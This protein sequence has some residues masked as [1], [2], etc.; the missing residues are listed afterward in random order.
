LREQFQAVRHY[1]Q[2]K[3]LPIAANDNETPRL[4][5][6]AEA[7]RYC[8]VTPATYAK[9]VMTGVLPPSLSVIGRTDMRALNAALDKLS[10]IEAIAEHEDSLKHGS[11]DAMRRH[12]PAL[13]ARSKSSP[14]EA[15]ALISMHG[16]AARC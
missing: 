7:A 11:E 13:I 15:P 12:L 9:W 16:A 5:S 6:K 2:E 3:R 8:G 1:L 14:M 4:V 10:G